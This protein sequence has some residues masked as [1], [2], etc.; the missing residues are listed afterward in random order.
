MKFYDILIIG[1]GPIGL[2]CALEAQ[3][4]GLSYL[5]VEKGTMANSIYRYPLYMRFFSTADKLE[6][7]NVPFISASP[8]PGRQDALEY[9]QGIS[10]PIRSI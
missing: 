7:G 8:K 2:N 10:A 3:R 9:Y 6:I 1:G 5:V 4:N